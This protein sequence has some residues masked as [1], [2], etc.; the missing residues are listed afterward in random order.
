MSERPTD[1]IETFFEEQGS[2]RKPGFIGRVVRFLLGAWLLWAL[3]TLLRYGW[4]ILVDTSPPDRIEWWLFMVLAFWLTPPVV[5]I[6]FTK[7]WRRA[8]Q[9]VIAVV[10]AAATGIDLLIYGTWW[11][12]PLGLFV[13]AWLVYF[14]AHLGSSFVLS[15]LL[16]TPGCEMRAIPHLWTLTTGRSTR[17]HYCPSFIDR[18]DRW[19]ADRG[20]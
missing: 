19:E 1:K 7:S 14:S 5:N 4:I 17:E 8:P 2:L 6:G 13:L 20:H 15:A 9:V 12:P 3:Y 11:A 16:A 10:A 18:L